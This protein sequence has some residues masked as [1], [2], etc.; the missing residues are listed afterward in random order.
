M[1]SLGSHSSPKFQELALQNFVRQELKFQDNFR[2]HLSCLNI[3]Q[4]SCNSPP[5][6]VSIEAYIPANI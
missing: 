2:S 6:L 1:K 3:Q 5:R 4:D